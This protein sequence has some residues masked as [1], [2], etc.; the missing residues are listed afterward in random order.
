VGHFFLGELAGLSHLTYILFNRSI[1][2]VTV[3]WSWAK[4]LVMAVCHKQ[5]NPTIRRKIRLKKRKSIKKRKISSVLTTLWTEYP[6][7]C[8]RLY[9]ILLSFFKN[10]YNMKTEKEFEKACS[11]MLKVK[12]T[13]NTM[14][15]IPTEVE[16]MFYENFGMSAEEINEVFS[17][18]AMMD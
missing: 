18:R 17:G 2:H 7:F 1:V 15:E 5:E 13:Y 4:V 12:W 8:L 11:I 10:K 16:N 3:V 6:C 14:P 9:S